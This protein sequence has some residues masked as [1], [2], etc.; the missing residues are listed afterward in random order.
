M[1]NVPHQY[2]LE[3]NYAYASFRLSARYTPTT[4][5]LNSAAV[6]F[7]HILQKFNYVVLVNS[8][9]ASITGMLFFMDCSFI[10]I[11]I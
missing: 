3:T 6:L 5:N 2:L 11:L 8:R 4:T 7:N 1:D 9:S 10:G